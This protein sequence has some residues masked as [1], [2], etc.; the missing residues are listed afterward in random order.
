METTETPIEFSEIE[1]A[2]DVQNFIS[3]SSDVVFNTQDLKKKI[4]D[5]NCDDLLKVT[6]KIASPI[7]IIDVQKVDE[8]FI[9]E[10]I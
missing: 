9:K 5:S 7:K 2:E 8:K 4:F 6:K 1:F 3:G 10:N